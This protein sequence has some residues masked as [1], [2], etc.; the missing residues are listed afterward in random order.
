MMDYLMIVFLL[1]LGTIIGIAA[2]VIFINMIWFL[3]NGEDD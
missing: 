2:I 1:S 3:E